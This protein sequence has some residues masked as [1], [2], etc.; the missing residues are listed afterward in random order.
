MIFWVRI[1]GRNPG[2]TGEAGAA[3]RIRVGPAW[4]QYPHPVSSRIAQVRGARFSGARK[5]RGPGPRSLPEQGVRRTNEWDRDPSSGRLTVYPG[6][7]AYGDA[8]A[9]RDS[10]FIPKV[11]SWNHYFGIWII[12]LFLFL[13]VFQGVEILGKKLILLSELKGKSNPK[14]ILFQIRVRPSLSIFYIEYHFQSKH[15]NFLSGLWSNSWIRRE[16]YI[17]SR[18]F[19]HFGMRLYLWIQL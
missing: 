16:K 1:P 11:F 7:R 15:Y 12:F 3:G 10:I 8:D 4:D 6:F 17:S 18:E 9:T 19:S 14:K 13:C 2:R 5:M